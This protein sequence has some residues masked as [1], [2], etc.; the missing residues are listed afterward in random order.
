[1]D[2]QNCRG[3]SPR[4][5]W[6]AGGRAAR[7]VAAA[8]TLGGVALA[9][10]T[11]AGAGLRAHAA[12]II[13][14]DVWV[15]N[16][17]GHAGPFHDDDRQLDCSPITVTGARFE[18]GGGSYE[19]LLITPTGRGQQVLKHDW[20]YDRTKRGIQLLDTISGADLVS[21]A[22]ALGI[23]AHGSTGYHFTFRFLQQPH[24]HKPFWVSADCPVK[25]A[26]LP[27]PAAAPPVAAAAPAPPA[28][29]TKAAAVTAPK[30]GADV[31]WEGALELLLGG[32]GCLGVARRLRRRRRLSRG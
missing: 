14:N 24:Q 11:L 25:A 13:P 26:A 16:V 2:D 8:M 18:H 5:R 4:G 12:E 15:D 22:K 7:S 31:P 20:T 21:S 17:G 29:G 28:T 9:S 19:I 1:M 6:G 3:G 27:P 32:V 23:S 10:A 30:T